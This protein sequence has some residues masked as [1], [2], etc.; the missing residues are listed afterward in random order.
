MTVSSPDIV[1]PSA[2][3]P[4]ACGAVGLADGRACVRRGPIERGVHPTD[5]AH[6]R[7]HVHATERLASHLL[8]TRARSLNLQ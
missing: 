7:P 5:A 6:L 3:T 2:R 1:R 4:R 8:T